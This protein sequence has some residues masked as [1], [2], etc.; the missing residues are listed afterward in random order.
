[1]GAFQLRAPMSLK[2]SF[3]AIDVPSHDLSGRLVRQIQ[4]PRTSASVIG[5]S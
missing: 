5:F 4:T 2:R 1:M 3:G